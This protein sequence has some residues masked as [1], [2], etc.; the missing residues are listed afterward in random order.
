[1]EKPVLEYTASEPNRLQRVEAARYRLAGEM[2]PR[3]EHCIRIGNLFRLAL[4]SLGPDRPPEVLSGKDEH[5]Q[6]LQLGHRHSLFL[7]EDADGDGR[8]DHLVFCAA[9]PVSE[10]VAHALRSLCRLYTAD[11]PSDSDASSHGQRLRD[12]GGACSW[13]VH[14][15][16]VGSRTQVARE[17]PLLQS[18]AVWVSSTPY[19]HPWF[20]KKHGKFGPEDQIRREA[21]LRDLPEL[22][23]IEILAEPRDQMNRSYPN[24]GMEGRYYPFGFDLVRTPGKI[25]ESLPDKQGRYVKITFSKPVTG[26]VVFGYGCHYGLG[27]FRPVDCP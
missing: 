15:E 5:G 7:P 21:E 26:P 9:Q 10:E 6:P 3:V 12:S 19:Y 22:M 23:D 27:L 4:M 18:S 17:T 25:K 11:F 16:V 1:M 8:I 14:M 13:M 2:L 24:S 20:R